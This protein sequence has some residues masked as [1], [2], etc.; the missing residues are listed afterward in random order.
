MD[1]VVYEIKERM[2]LELYIK[3]A[4]RKEQLLF[5]TLL[6]QKLQGTLF[7]IQNLSKEY[8]HQLYAVEGLVDNQIAMLFVVERNQITELRNQWKVVKNQPHILKAG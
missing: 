1:K 5:A 3:N 8:L 4:L 6:E 7:S 2:R